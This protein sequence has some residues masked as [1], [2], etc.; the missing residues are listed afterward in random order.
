[1]SLLGLS[2]QASFTH[3]DTHLN[4]RNLTVAPLLTRSLAHARVQQ[5]SRQALPF[6]SEPGFGWGCRPGQAGATART[7]P[8]SASLAQAEATAL[9]DSRDLGR[10]F[11]RAAFQAMSS[12]LSFAEF[13]QKT[14]NVRK[15][16]RPLG[17]FLLSHQSLKP[18]ASD[19]HREQLNTSCSK[20]AV[21]F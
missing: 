18:E 11:L 12:R 19:R 16:G 1:M 10:A 5:E 21:E 8:G 6:A 7:G 3:A 9:A 4:I 20:A 15:K 14:V 13:P 17:L 2:I